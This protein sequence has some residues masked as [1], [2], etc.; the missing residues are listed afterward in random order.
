MSAKEYYNDY[1][2]EIKMMTK[3]EYQRSK[4]H[5]KSHDNYIPIKKI[6]VELKIKA[7]DHLDEYIDD[8]ESGE[9][10]EVCCEAPLWRIEL[11]HCETIEDII[12]YMNELGWQ[13][14]FDEIRETLDEVNMRNDFMVCV[15][16]Y[17]VHHH[18][19]IF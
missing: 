6:I 7:E 5:K 3:K 1:S 10:G 9:D 2:G 14:V 13:K 17:L 12:D 18:R 8:W 4:K 15:M 19:V 11:K 16:H